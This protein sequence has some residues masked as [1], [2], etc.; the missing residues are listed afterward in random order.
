MKGAL[1]AALL[2]ACPASSPQ[3]PAPAPAPPASE[4]APTEAEQCRGY[5]ATVSRC[6]PEFAYAE[7]EVDCRQ[8]LASPKGSEVSGFTPSL[9]RCWAEAASCPL[10]AACDVAE[11]DRK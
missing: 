8:L 1:L 5:C 10:A 4:R 7:C 11:G 6:W 9:V 3:P 2:L